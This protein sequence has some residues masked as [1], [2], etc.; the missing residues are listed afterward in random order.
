MQNINEYLNEQY[1]EGTEEM[2]HINAIKQKFIDYLNDG[3]KLGIDQSVIYAQ[4][5]NRFVSLSTVLDKSIELYN[6]TKEE[7]ERTTKELSIY[8]DFVKTLTNDL[9]KSFETVRRN[10]EKYLM[11]DRTD[12]CKRQKQFANDFAVKYLKKR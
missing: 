3:T 2:K 10:R 6:D 8:K 12:K 9:Q 4:I 5:A 7:L 11:T 1:Q